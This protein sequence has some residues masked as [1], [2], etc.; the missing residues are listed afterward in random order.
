MRRTPTQMQD[1]WE[2]SVVTWVNC[3]LGRPFLCFFVPQFEIVTVSCPQNTEDWILHRHFCASRFYFSH[4]FYSPFCVYFRCV[5]RSMVFA[6]HFCAS[7]SCF[8]VCIFDAFC[9][10]W[11]MCHFWTCIFSRV[12][13][14]GEEGCH[15]HVVP[16]G[17]LLLKAEYTHV[18]IL[19]FKLLQFCTAYGFWIVIPF[20]FSLHSLQCIIISHCQAKIWPRAYRR[21]A[22]CLFR[23]TS[24]EEKKYINTAKCSV[25]LWDLA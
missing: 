21:Q 25:T 14:R 18:R 12:S 11:F 5:L 3:L 7:R 6:C 24:K 17:Q 4:V 16:P 22:A 1:S 10:H 19:V 9:A 15:L 8:F 13:F 20:S 2:N 23:R